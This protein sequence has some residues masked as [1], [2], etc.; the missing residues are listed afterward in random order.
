M[1]KL[2]FKKR[3]SGIHAVLNPQGEPLGVVDPTDLD[4]DD[5]ELSQLLQKHA[6]KRAAQGAVAEFMKRIREHMDKTGT[7]YRTAL[8]EVATADPI[9][10]SEYRAE[11][12][13]ADLL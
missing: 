4:L 9:L 5:D 11:Q 8:H 12:L 13:A 7:D 2:A 6:E 3:A 1:Q 10:A